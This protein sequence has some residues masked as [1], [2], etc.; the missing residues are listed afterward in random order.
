MTLLLVLLLFQTSQ[1]A[2]EWRVVNQANGQ[3][4]ARALVIERDLATNNSSYRYTNEHGLF[5]FSAL[6]PGNYTVRV[7]ALGFRPE[8]RS[9]VELPVASHIEIN[10]ALTA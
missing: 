5:Y 4:V 6:P 2:L 9:P 1:A 3:P 7:D 10:F 8:E